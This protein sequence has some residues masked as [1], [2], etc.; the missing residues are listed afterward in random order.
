MLAVAGK[1]IDTSAYDKVSVGFVCL[2]K[3]FIDIALTVGDM[4]TSWSVEKVCRL[5]EVRQPS[6]TFFLLDGNSRRIDLLLERVGALKF[7]SGPEFNGRQAERKPVRC[8]DQARMHQNPADSNE[9][10]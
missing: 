7:L 8:H 10:D 9:C 5:T 6:H 1:T 4:N 2:T 3:K